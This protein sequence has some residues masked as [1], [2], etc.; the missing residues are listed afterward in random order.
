MS[1]AFSYGLKTVLGIG[2][3]DS[4]IIADHTADTATTARD[5]LNEA[6]HG[7]DSCSVLVTTSR[8][9]AEAVAAEVA[10]VGDTFSEK[11]EILA[12]SFGPDGLSG[13]AVAPDLDAAVAFANQFA[14]EHMIVHVESAAEEQLIASV[15]NCGELLVGGSTPFSAGNYAVGITAVLPTNGFAEA[16]SGITCRDMMKTTTIGR[17][18]SSALAELHPTIA[19]LGQREGLPWHVEA[20]RYRMEDTE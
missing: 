13:V 16:I 1:L 5:L 14:P 4:L 20:S 11:R 3:T 15:D 10:R 6:E 12:H 19:A 18:S 17:L 7:P 8:V 9:L 2:P